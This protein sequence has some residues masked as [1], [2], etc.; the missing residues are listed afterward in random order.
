M[1]KLEILNPDMF[2]G[3]IEIGINQN[4][5][6]FIS[7]MFD[8]NYIADSMGRYD[9]DFCDMVYRWYVEGNVNT[10]NYSEEFLNM[11]NEERFAKYNECMT[12]YVR[13]VI[14]ELGMCSDKIELSFFE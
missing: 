6:E 12:E 13:K 14:S 4:P 3:A 9:Y 2:D 7:E 10:D 1:K 8:W 5:F 11:T